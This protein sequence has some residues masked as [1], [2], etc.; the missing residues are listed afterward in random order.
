MA[1]LIINRFRPY[2]IAIT[3]SSGKTTVKY[4]TGE[5]LKA[6]GFDVLVAP[7]NM[8]T[9]TGLPLA[10]I[11]F[12]KPPE[13]IAGWAAAFIFSPFMAFFKLKYP[14]YLVLEYAADKP[15]DIRYLLKI[16]EPDIAV[17]TNIGVA[18]I[19]AF[20]TIE[21]ILEEK[22]QL[23]VSA[24]QKVIC[25]QDVFEKA[26]KIGYPRAEVVS[27]SFKTVKARNIKSFTNK[28]GFELYIYGQKGVGEFEFL[29]KHNILNLE[30]ATLAAISAGADRE[31]IME[32][33]SH[34]SPQSGRG[35]RVN[36][37][38][39]FVIIDESYNA[40]PLSMV[41]AL[42]ILA[43]FKLSRRVA[44]LGEMKEIAPISEKS[45]REVASLARKTAD[46]LIGVGEGFKGL[47]LDKWYP[48]VEELNREINTLLK[49]GDVVL[50]KGSH[51]NHLEKLIEKLG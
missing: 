17:I 4:M 40:N 29:G 25:P 19:E 35:N 11:G 6:S 33:T 26:K 34:L 44:I 42:E 20:G 23:A 32:A 13:T 9:E 31:K 7:G 37:S 49:K 2:V 43:R 15:E 45:H 3:G 1:R 21:N 48:N 47:D 5:F 30:L 24:R 51:A 46:Y 16:A 28:T 22:W 10:I 39:D 14:K 41:A 50:V 12:S 8:N 38:K 18:H 36:S 27:P